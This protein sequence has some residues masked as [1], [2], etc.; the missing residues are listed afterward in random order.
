M[1]LVR[2]VTWCQ[3]AR[4]PL[5]SVPIQC[6][7]PFDLAES[8]APSSS[9][10]SQVSGFPLVRNAQ[11]TFKP[12]ASFGIGYFLKDR[13]DS[14]VI[15]EAKL[16]GSGASNSATAPAVEERIKMLRRRNAELERERKDVLEKLRRVQGREDGVKS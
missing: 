3:I 11:L 4:N 6:W 15:K 9:P 14:N 1:A 16:L 2:V 7:K 12:A 13:A 8:T 5:F 10:S